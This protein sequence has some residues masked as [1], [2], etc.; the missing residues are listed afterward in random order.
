MQYVCTSGLEVRLSVADIQAE[1]SQL[2]RTSMDERKYIHLFASV[3]NIRCCYYSLRNFARKIFAIRDICEINLT[4]KF[5]DPRYMYMHM[6]H[7]V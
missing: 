1:P 4:A 7:S 3:I 2:P 5:P 6:L